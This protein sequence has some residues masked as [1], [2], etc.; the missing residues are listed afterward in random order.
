WKKEG[1]EKQPYYF[2]L[3]HETLFAFAGLYSIWHDTEGKEV[4]SYTIITTKPNRVVEP[5]HDRMPV[6]LKKEDESTW[7]N[8]DI[9]EPARLLPLLAPYSDAAMEAYPVSPQVNSP[10]NDTKEVLQR[11]AL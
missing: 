11:I 4:K 3:K 7:L 2:H 1:K 10:K 6:I 9:T 8:P 5:I